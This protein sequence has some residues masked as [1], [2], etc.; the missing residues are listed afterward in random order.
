MAMIC[1][2]VPASWLCVLDELESLKALEDVV[3]YH[4][5]LVMCQQCGLPSLDDYTLQEECKYLLSYLTTLGCILWIDEPIIRDLVV[6][7]S[8]LG[9]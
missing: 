2:Q 9:A 8:V 7:V 1:T 6:L 4:D 3:S 5:V